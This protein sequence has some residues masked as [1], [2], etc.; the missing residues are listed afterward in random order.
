MVI[1]FFKIKPTTRSW[2]THAIQIEWVIIRFQVFKDVGIQFCI[3]TETKRRQNSLNDTFSCSYINVLQYLSAFTYPRI[4]WV[5]KCPLANTTLCSLLPC[6]NKTVDI[7]LCLNGKIA[8]IPLSKFFTCFVKIEGF[9]ITRLT[10]SLRLLIKILYSPVLYIRVNESFER[11]SRILRFT[12]WKD[13][14]NL[15]KCT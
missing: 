3:S 7:W 12:P 1:V 4:I 10:E 14:F 9:K 13:K 11:M 2:M 5:G 15:Y 6:G 8:L